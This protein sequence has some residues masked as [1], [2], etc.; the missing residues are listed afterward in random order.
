MEQAQALS[1]GN[2]ALQDLLGSDFVL[3]PAVLPERAR[4]VLNER[5]AYL[6][7]GAQPKT[8]EVRE[9]LRNL[10]IDELLKLAGS[11]NRDLLRAMTLFGRCPRRLSEL[12]LGSAATSA[13]CA[14]LGC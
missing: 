3:R 7:G 9:F 14:T 4:A 12:L 1:R 6:E 2:P 10:A 8:E 11:A 13:G 5:E